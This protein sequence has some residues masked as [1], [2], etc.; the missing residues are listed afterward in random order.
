MDL[1]VLEVALSP[2]DIGIVINI[3]MK[4]WPVLYPASPLDL[5][6]SPRKEINPKI[7]TE[8]QYRVGLMTDLALV[9]DGLVDLQVTMGTAVLVVEVHLS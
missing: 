4:E 8:L 1:G 6:N 2:K 7:Q 3:L 5:E 9:Q